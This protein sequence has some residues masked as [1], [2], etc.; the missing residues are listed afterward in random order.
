MSTTYDDLGHSTFPNQVDE[1]DY[2]IDADANVIDKIKDYQQAIDNKQYS[3]AQEILDEDDGGGQGYKIKDHI[4]TAENY[5]VLADA[6][7][8]VERYI[9]DRFNAV[10]TDLTNKLSNAIHIR[11]SK[12]GDNEIDS[13]SA[14]SIN[15]SENVFQKKGYFVTIKILKDN[16]TLQEG[17]VSPMWIYS[18]ED[19]DNTMSYNTASGEPQDGVAYLPEEY[20]LEIDMSNWNTIERCKMWG[21]HMFVGYAS[22]NWI[23]TRVGIP[24][25]D[26]WALVRVMRK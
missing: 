12:S 23:G 13:T 3:R 22:N 26:L 2:L 18:F 11:Y 16:W 1:I 8:A 20:D 7:M 4:F 15:G 10:L 6:I 21:K 5:N 19:P 25:D 24:T 9:K 17:T 14:Y